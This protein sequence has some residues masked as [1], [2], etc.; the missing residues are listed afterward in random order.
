VT[1]NTF[2]SLNVN[3]PVDGE[4]PDP[5]LE[6][7]TEV[8][9]TGKETD[10]GFDL[11]LR[12]RAEERRMFA[13]AR[14]RYSREMNAADDA[15]GLP[16]DSYDLAAEWGPSA[17]DIRHRI[18]G[19]VS[20]GLPLKLGLNMSARVDSPSPYTIRTGFDDNGDTVTNDR[21]AGVGR[22]SERGAWQRSADLRLSWRSDDGPPARRGRRGDDDDDDGERRRGIEMYIDVQNVFNTT[23]FTSYSGVMTSPYFRLPTAAGSGRR[24]ELGTRV[25]F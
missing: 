23:N 7:I 6:R 19:H 2:R 22:N 20:V 16:A 24:M 13:F 8:R 1:S 25:F 17:N 10:R 4:R 14:Y 21:P 3:A 15:L 9:S 5:Q 11:G 12:L 18:F